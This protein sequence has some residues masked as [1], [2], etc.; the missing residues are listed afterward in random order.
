MEIYELRDATHVAYFFLNYGR[1]WFHFQEAS[2]QVISH[3]EEGIACVTCFL[4]TSRRVGWEEH[5]TFKK[6]ADQGGVEED[7]SL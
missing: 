3:L 7:T 5:D 2:I 1:L 6:A 4:W